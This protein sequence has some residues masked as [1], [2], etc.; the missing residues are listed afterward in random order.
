MKL[1]FIKI[2]ALVSIFLLLSVFCF[3]QIQ[4]DTNVTIQQLV[5][6][7]TGPGIVEV[8]NISYQGV[9]QARGLFSNA[10]S[11]II[12]MDNGIFLC[13][14]SGANIPGPNSVSDAGT[15]NWIGGHPSLQA[16]SSGIT[17]D[18]SVLEF[19][20]IPMNDTLRCFSFFGSEEYNEHVFSDYNDLSAIFLTGPNPMGGMYNN[21]NIAII[22]GTTNT[23]VSINNVNNGNWPP[24]A[25][26]SGPCT[27]CSY[28]FDNPIGSS[29]EYDGIVI[30]FAWSLVTPYETYHIKIGIAD[31]GGYGYDSGLFLEEQGLFFLGPAE[32]TSFRFLIENNPALSFDVIGEIVGSEVFIEVPYGTDI[33][34]LVASYEDL[35]SFVYVDD[36]LQTSGKTSNDYTYPVIYHFEGHGIADYAVNLE[37]VTDVQEI[38]EPR[39]N[40]YPNP[41]NNEVNFEISTQLCFSSKEVRGSMNDLE[42]RIIDMYGKV[43]RTFSHQPDNFNKICKYRL[44]TRNLSSGIYYFNSKIGKFQMN[45]KL[46]IQKK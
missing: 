45:G 15:E 13:T 46:I 24:G 38:S 6:K 34:N 10:D 22:P 37:V 25:I 18:A 16:I 44:D 30:N 33:T 31:V 5:E 39:V 42:I 12:G 17:Y 23:S 8:D 21:K 41:A 2:Y 35:G 27:N 20:F 36:E 11:S 9:N 14:G 43:V 40:V 1:Q 28:F 32:L 4:I 19:D 29:I 26:S 3:A 7:F